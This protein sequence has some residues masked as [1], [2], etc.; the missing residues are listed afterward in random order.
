MDHV[1]QEDYSP[2]LIP[3]LSNHNATV[4]S[5]WV[6]GQ[7]KSPFENPPAKTTKTT[8]ILERI[9]SERHLQ[10]AIMLGSNG[11]KPSVHG[12]S[13]ETMWEGR[14]RERGAWSTGTQ[15]ECRLH[16]PGPFPPAEHFWGDVEPQR[17]K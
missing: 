7:V 14:S 15:G 13:A 10:I 9:G 8:S 16:P 12:A 4:L 17:G 3:H 6:W 2:I 1:V 11:Q 5:S